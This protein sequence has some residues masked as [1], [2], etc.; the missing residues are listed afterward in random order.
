MRNAHIT[1]IAV[2]NYTYIRLIWRL[3]FAV[4]RRLTTASRSIL[5]LP[6][7]AALL[8]LRIWGCYLMAGDAFRCFGCHCRQ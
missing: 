7:D 4:I 1:I 3:S 2:S 5:I 6:P 8:L